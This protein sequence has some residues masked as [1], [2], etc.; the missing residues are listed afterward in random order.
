MLRVW[1]PL[2]KAVHYLLETAV[3][4]SLARFALTPLVIILALTSSVEAETVSFQE[5]VR[6]D[7][8]SIAVNQRTKNGM[9]TAEIYRPTDSKPHP[10][11]IVLHGCGGVDDFHREWAKRLVK[12]GYLAIIP[13]SFG[14][15]GRG[16]LCDVEPAKRIYPGTRMYDVS[17]TAKWLSTQPD[18]QHD[19]VAVLG[20]SM[21]GEVVMWGVQHRNHLWRD[22]GIKAAIAYYPWCTP[23]RQ[24]EIAIPTL[25]QMGEKD[26]WNSVPNCKAI[27]NQPLLE[28]HFFPDSYHDFDR[29]GRTRWIMGAGAD[30]VHSRKL[31]YN[32]KAAHEAMD[33]TERFLRD[34]LGRATNSR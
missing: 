6:P 29:E 3:L 33:N 7:V 23:D 26:D 9:L 19:K 24:R 18:V 22:Y 21:G 15:R 13:D 10:A 5:I 25:L 31:E 30:G 2:S 34:H 27:S 14:P 4:Y 12:W 32:S 1:P 20:F 17:A 28:A 11:V 8:A 16:S